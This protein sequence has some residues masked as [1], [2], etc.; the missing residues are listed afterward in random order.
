MIKFMHLIKPTSNPIMN[1]QKEVLWIEKVQGL[2]G[3]ASLFFII[4]TINGYLNFIIKKWCT[5][6]SLVNIIVPITRSN[7]IG[8]FNFYYSWWDM[9]LKEVTK[10]NWHKCCKTL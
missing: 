2:V 7:V 8:I 5:N 4:H 3:T 6:F 1:M 10:N 9:L